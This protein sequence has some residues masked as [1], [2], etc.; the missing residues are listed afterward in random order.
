MRSERCRHRAPAKLLPLSLPLSP[1]PSHLRGAWPLVALALVGC[2]GTSPRAQAPALRAAAAE[3]SPLS[4]E[5]AASS[6]A[7]ASPYDPERVAPNRYEWKRALGIV[8]EPAKPATLHF[9]GSVAEFPLLPEDDAS[10]SA[11]VITVVQDTNAADTRSPDT[12][13][14]GL[15]PRFRTCF[16]QLQE[17]RGSAQGNARLSLELACSGAVTA[18]SAETQQLDDEAVACLFGLV[19]PTTFPPPPGGHGSLQLPVVFRSNER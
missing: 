10:R 8:C 12:I 5:T 7:S 2:G 17:R 14:A 18:I 15:R 1:A 4:V 3:A 6:A 16:A 13:V 11:A 9:T 19:A